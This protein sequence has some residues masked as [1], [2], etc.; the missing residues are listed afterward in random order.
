MDS[1]CFAE[2]YHF[3]QTI[4]CM[5]LAYRSGKQATSRNKKSRT[6]RRKDCGSKLK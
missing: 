4:L 2:L 6:T 5:V 3:L 1:F